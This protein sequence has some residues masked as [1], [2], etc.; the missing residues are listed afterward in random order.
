MSL[1]NYIKLHSEGLNEYCHQLGIQDRIYCY[2]ALDR[3]TY[4]QCYIAVRN[5]EEL[6]FVTPT[7]KEMRR[8]LDTLKTPVP[9]GA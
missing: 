8:K 9:V 1:E 2:D 5:F 4:E 7:A 3:T 6:L